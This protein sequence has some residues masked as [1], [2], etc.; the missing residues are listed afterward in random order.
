MVSVFDYQPKLIGENFSIR[1]LTNDDFEN[2]YL[3]SSDKKIWEGHPV[4]DRY[5]KD[6]FT[7][8]FQN[9]IESKATV[10]FIDNS[11]GN[12]IGSSRFYTID[13]Y[14]NDMAIGYTFLSRKYWGGKANLELKKLMINHVFECFDSVWFHV[15]KS[16]IRSQKAIQKIGA[17]FM[18][19]K[20]IEIGGSAD[21][22]L[23][24]KIEKGR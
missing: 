7:K 20:A 2:L 1:A 23:F 13:D 17:V 15:A 10:V 18:Y 5:K 14:P 9:A 3:C 8:S 11:N 16:N 24:Y 4:K 12:I 6:I 22:W 19:E 21:N